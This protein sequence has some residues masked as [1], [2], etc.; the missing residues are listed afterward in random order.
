M[1]IVNNIFNLKADADRRDLRNRVE[2]ADDTI[3]WAQEPERIP[4]WMCQTGCG[5]TLVISDAGGL[6]RQ[7]RV[8][9]RPASRFET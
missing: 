8:E 4:P 1:N 3:A 7:C 9:S 2:T 5:N 6:C